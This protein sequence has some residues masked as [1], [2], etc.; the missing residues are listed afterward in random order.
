MLHGNAAKLMGSRLALMTALALTG[1]GTAVAQQGQAG[2]SQQGQQFAQPEE[3][4]T[5]VILVPAG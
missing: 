1:A 2:Q 4:T 3:E 5:G